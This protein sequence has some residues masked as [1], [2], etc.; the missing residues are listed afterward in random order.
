MKLIN[1]L[2]KLLAISWKKS[3]KVCQM[4]SRLNKT[5]R[6][7]Y[8]LTVLSYFVISNDDINESLSSIDPDIW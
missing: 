6:Y 4:T 7:N 1:K 2:I 3:C 5:L 8:K